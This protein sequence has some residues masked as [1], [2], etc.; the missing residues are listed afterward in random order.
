MWNEPTKDRLSKIPKLQ[1]TENIPLQEKFIYL[2]FFIGDC[3]WFIAEYNGKDTFFG[4][5]ILKNFEMAEWGYI[6]FTELKGIKINGVFEVDNDLHWK[7][8][9]AIEVEAICKAQNWD[10]EKYKL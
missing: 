2:H 6:S 7:V 10:I 8:R 4:F 5:A 1:E 9:P 3:D